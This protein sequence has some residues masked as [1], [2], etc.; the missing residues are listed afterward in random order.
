MMSSKASITFKRSRQAASLMT[1]VMSLIA[2]QCD[3]HASLVAISNKLHP[4]YVNRE[5]AGSDIESCQ[6][7]S[8]SLQLL[9]TVLPRKCFVFGMLLIDRAGKAC[10]S[11]LINSENVLR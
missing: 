6:S 2:E 9:S 10:K 8:T 3:K 5:G 11:F 4:E 7:L 1:K